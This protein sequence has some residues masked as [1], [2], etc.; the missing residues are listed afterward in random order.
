MED[1]LNIL[2]VAH[3]DDVA[4]LKFVGILNHLIQ[5]YVWLVW[6]DKN[7]MLIHT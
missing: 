1:K 6:L 4:K 3:S 2:T 7:Y 5:L